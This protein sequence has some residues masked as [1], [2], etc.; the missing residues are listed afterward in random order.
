MAEYREGV[1]IRDNTSPYAGTMGARHLSQIAKA[2]LQSREGRALEAAIAWGQA[3]RYAPNRGAQIEALSGLLRNAELALHQ[4]IWEAN[5]DGVSWRILGH[6]TDLSWQTLHRRYRTPPIR[7]RPPPDEEP[8]NERAERRRERRM[9]QAR[10][11][12]RRRR[13]TS[14]P[15]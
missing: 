13:P 9:A 2:E 7:M 3:A 10:K 4:A 12:S 15:G 5:R 8:R 11:P 1:R 6:Y 14:A